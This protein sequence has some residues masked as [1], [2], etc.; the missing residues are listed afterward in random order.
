MASRGKIQYFIPLHS[1]DIAE[2]LKWWTIKTAFAFITS[3]L[4]TYH[5]FKVW[6]RKKWITFS[7][8]KSSIL[9]V[10][11]HHFHD[12]D[13]LCI[14]FLCP[15]CFDSN[16]DAKKYTAFK[17]WPY[18]KERKIEE[19]SSINSFPCVC[20]SNK[21]MGKG[22]GKQEV[23][24][25]EFTDQVIQ[26]A[27]GHELTLPLINACAGPGGLFLKNK[28]LSSRYLA[29]KISGMAPLTEEE[30]AIC[31]MNADFDMMMI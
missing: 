8:P 2:A 10:E 15:H 27:Y 5:S 3:I 12:M 1:M 31:L 18:E 23:L 4:K 26:D 9:S 20:Q 14:D 16:P 13:V 22:G 17:E 30:S 6:R 29:C 11:E 25:V 19:V 24:S 21:E 7:P 28:T